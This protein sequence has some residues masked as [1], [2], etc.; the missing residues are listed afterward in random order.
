MRAMASR[1]ANG[2]GPGPVLDAGAAQDEFGE[3]HRR[4]TGRVGAGGVIGA[5]RSVRVGGGLDGRPQ[6]RAGQ[7]EDGTVRVLA[8]PHRHHRTGRVRQLD[9]V[10]PVLAAAARLAPGG[11][12]QVHFSSA[13]LI[14]S[15]DMSSGSALARNSRSVSES[16]ARSEGL[17][18]VMPRTVVSMYATSLRSSMVATTKAPPVPAGRPLLRTIWMVTLGSS[19]RAIRC[20][21]CSCITSDEPTR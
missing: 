12:A 19:L 2:D 15:R 20:L 16:L 5:G 10:A 17:S 9:A 3:A 6:G 4:S 7:E 14:M 8:V 13:S 11:V 18:V 21:V 1:K